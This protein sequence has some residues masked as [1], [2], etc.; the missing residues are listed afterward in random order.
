MN[1][2]K[3]KDEVVDEDE[4]LPVAICKNKPVESGNPKKKNNSAEGGVINSGRI[5]PILVSGKIYG[6]KAVHVW[7]SQKL[8]H[9]PMPV[10]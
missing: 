8:N 2:F 3:E 6:S 7:T 1:P 4:K 5:L 10:V 9:R